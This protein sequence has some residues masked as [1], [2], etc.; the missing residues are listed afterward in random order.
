MGCS[1]GRSGSSG[2]RSGGGS[3]M[4]IM[5]LAVRDACV[6]G[7]WLTA[8]LLSVCC[9]LPSCLPAAGQTVDYSSVE[10]VVSRQGDTAILR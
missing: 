3:V 7:Q 4:D 2:R 8:I 5:L 10:S 6:S 9:F 1:S